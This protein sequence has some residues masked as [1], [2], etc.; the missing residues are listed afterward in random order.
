MLVFFSNFWVVF[1]APS[2]YWAWLWPYGRSFTNIF[3][4]NWATS[5][6]ISAQ[7]SDFRLFSQYTDFCK[8]FSISAE[9]PGI[10]PKICGQWKL[11]YQSISV[12]NLGSPTWIQKKIQNWRRLSSKN[13]R[14]FPKQLFI[15]LGKILIPGGKIILEIGYEKTK[16]DIDKLFS[17]EGF[18]C[19]WHKDLND[20]YRVVE[21][22]FE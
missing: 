18:K 5:V 15:N 13:D 21:I 19:I 4:S 6:L 10:W 3:F 8:N 1:V 7:F 14:L 20:N 11:V 2:F 17:K 12:P 16:P 9:W 22:F